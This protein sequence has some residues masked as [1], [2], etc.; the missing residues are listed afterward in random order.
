MKEEAGSRD[1]GEPARVAQYGSGLVGSEERR[2]S[3][4][5]GAGEL[6]SV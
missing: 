1:S 5:E 4:P 6:R 2:G 3:C